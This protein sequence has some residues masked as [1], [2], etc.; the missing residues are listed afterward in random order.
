MNNGKFTAV[1]I[2]SNLLD[3]DTTRFREL[4]GLR[5]LD[6]L[7]DEYNGK[8]EWRADGSPDYKAC[9]P[10][11]SVITVLGRVWGP[12]YVECWCWRDIGHEDCA[13][14]QA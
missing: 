5:L 2:I 13:A 10:D 12:G 14:E 4:H 7:I 6:D 3:G 9:F 8:I 1:K 11:G